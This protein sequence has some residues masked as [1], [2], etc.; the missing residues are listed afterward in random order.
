MIF[1]MLLRFV[2]SELTNGGTSVS[3]GRGNITCLCGSFLAVDHLPVF[4]TLCHRLFA[5]LLATIMVLNYFPSF[6]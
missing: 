4:L 5:G 2:Q 1:L 3:N 6:R